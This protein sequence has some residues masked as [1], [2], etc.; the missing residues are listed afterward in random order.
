VRVAFSWWWVGNGDEDP[1]I[2]PKLREDTSEITNSQL[3]HFAALCVLL[4]GTMSLVDVF[5]RHRTEQA[6]I[7]ALLAVGMGTLGLARPSVIRPV[8][9]ALLVLTAPIGWVVSHVLMAAIFC[10]VFTP[11][12]LAFKLVRRDALAR[13]FNKNA[14]TYWSERQQSTDPRSYLH[15]S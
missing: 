7:L 14:A 15:Q 8:F 13:R 9:S 11:I 12:A 2:D 4:F 5:G 1:M 6:A 3:R 10:V